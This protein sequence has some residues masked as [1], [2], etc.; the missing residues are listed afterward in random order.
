MM[1]TQG[2]IYLDVRSRLEF[3]EG[4]PAGAIN[5]PIEFRSAQRN[6]PNESFVEDVLERFEHRT[7]L[8]LGCRSGVRSIGACRLLADSGFSNIVEQ[9]LGTRGKTDEFGE[10]VEPGWNRLGL[11]WSRD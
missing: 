10:V 1:R 7:K 3:S 5:I 11:P 6:G 2:Y 4:H 8:I 9:K